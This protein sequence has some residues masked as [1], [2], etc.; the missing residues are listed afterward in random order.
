M[1]DI[2]GSDQPVLNLELNNAESYITDRDRIAVNVSPVDV[3]WHLDHLLKV[4]IGIHLS[5][6]KSEP[7]KFKYSWNFYRSLA[8]TLDRIPRGFAMSSKS[9]LP[10]DIIK[11]I[12][13]SAQLKHARLVLQKF[14]ELDKNHFFD[15]FLLGLLDRDRAL[16]FVGIHTRH[17]LRII[18]DIVK[19]SKKDENS[20]E[21]DKS[22]LTTNRD[23]L[24]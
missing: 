24:H 6:D 3:A 1:D 14:S 4:I 8:F 21:T 10:P 18:R 7:A 16:K 9:V 2:K 12:D 5:L 22:T 11:T 17:H 23:A 20:Q 15:H 19:Q 13:I